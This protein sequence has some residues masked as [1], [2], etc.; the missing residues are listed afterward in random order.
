MRVDA[1]DVLVQ[2]KLGGLCRSLGAR[3]GNA[4]DR[5]GAQRALVRRA[6]Q[7]EHDLVDGALIAGFD[8]H[9]G[10]RDLLVHMADGIQRALAQ[11]AALVAIT[12]LDGLE[13]A[14]GSTGGHC[15]PAER[16][17]VQHN[18]DLDGGVAAGIQHFAAEYIDDDA[19]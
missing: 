11:V 14:R 7:L 10:I 4:Q 13:R 9:Q 12:Q 2:G 18:L 19:H 15:S 6:V 8:A 3:Q 1:A 16:A 5:V 17:V